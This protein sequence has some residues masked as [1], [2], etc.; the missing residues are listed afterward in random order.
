[1]MD[2]LTRREKACAR[3]RRYYAR[4]R[5]RLCEQARKYYDVHREQER[6]RDRRYHETHREQRRE[7]NPERRAAT[8]KYKKANPEKFQARNAIS[9]GIRDGKITRGPCVV[10]GN[11]KTQKH[12][13]DYS[14][15]LEV[16][17]MCSRHHGQSH[18]L[19]PSRTRDS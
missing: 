19:P 15:P 4:H 16:V 2:A 3:K 11:P 9:N 10:C 1:M 12:H 14:K 8:A 18:R 7:Y 5:E 6:E 13:P 17:D